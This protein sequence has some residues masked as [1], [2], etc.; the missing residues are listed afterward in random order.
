MGVLNL[1]LHQLHGGRAGWDAIV[2]EHRHGTVTVAEHQRN[3]QQVGP[4]CFRVRLVASIVRGNLNRATVGQETK[5][6]PNLVVRE[7]HCL[8]GMAFDDVV[9]RLLH[10]VL[11]LHRTIR[12]VVLL[13]VLS[14]SWQD[15]Q[16]QRQ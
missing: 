16:H 1:R 2:Y 5:M 6:M 15:E 7:A 11:L 8:I 9:V 3:V 4:N 13:C 12:R 10:G 14:A